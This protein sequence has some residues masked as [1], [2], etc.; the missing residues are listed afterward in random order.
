MA[1]SYE[2][3]CKYSQNLSSAVTSG[4]EESGC[5]TGGHSGEVAVLYDMCFFGGGEGTNI[6]FL[7][8]DYFR[9]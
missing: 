5:C 9:K 2:F 6:L 3:V 1:A 8:N 7:K 4:T